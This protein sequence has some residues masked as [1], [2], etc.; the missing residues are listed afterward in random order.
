MRKPVKKN[1]AKK[2]PAKKKKS[3]KWALRPLLISAL[4]KLFMQSPIFNY[5][6]SQARVDD[7]YG[8]AM[9]SYTCNICKKKFRDTKITV[10]N[11]KGKKVQK[12]SIAID[13]INP[14]VCVEEGFVDWSTYIDRMFGFISSWDKSNPNK[15]VLKHFQLCCFTCHELKSKLENSTRRSSKRSLSISQSLHLL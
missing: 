4:R 1:P 8:R 13:H 9:Y 3:D 7:K 10:L 6:K 5:V 14:V 12:H 2:N 15:E 11:A